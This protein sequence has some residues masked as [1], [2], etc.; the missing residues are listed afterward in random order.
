M[1]D[2]FYDD[3]NV[4]D[5]FTPDKDLKMGV[6]THLLKYARRYPKDLVCLAICAVVVLCRC[7]W[8]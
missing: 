4:I 1:S 3:D 5:E 7:R 8:L 6:W 2:A